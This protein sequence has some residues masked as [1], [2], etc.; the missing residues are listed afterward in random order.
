MFAKKV[1]SVPPATKRITREDIFNPFSEEFEIHPQQEDIVLAVQD[2][3]TIIIDSIAGSSK[4]ISQVII[5]HNYPTPSL[6]LTFSK[7]L[8]EE[9]KSVFPDYVDCRTIH[10]LAYR[11]MGRS[12]AHKLSR[13]K[14]RYINVAGTGS[15]IAKYYKIKT[16]VLK[17]LM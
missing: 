15:E 13:P 6:Y 10:S 2:N 11:E 14:G 17:V 4:T 5:A 16:F 8:A 3:D 1:G 9:A 12:I 7:A